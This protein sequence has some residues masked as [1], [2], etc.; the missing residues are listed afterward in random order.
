MDPY[1]RLVGKSPQR[2]RF[3]RLRLFPYVC[4]FWLAIWLAAAQPDRTYLHEIQKWRQDYEAN[5]K[6]DNGWLSLAGLFWLKDGE[7][8][9]G[10]GSANTIVLPAGSAPETAGTFIFHDGKTRLAPGRGGPL[11]LNGQPVR[12]ETV[13]KPDSSGNPDRI[14]LGRLSMIVIQRGAR[15]GIRLWD[16]GSPVRR[17]FR[18]THWFPVQESYRVTATFHSYPQPKMIP[19]LNILGDTAPNPS[20]GFATF[21]MGGKPCRLEA[22]L[23]DNQLFFMF[24]DTTGG[25]ETYP[26]GRFLYSG[27]P[28]NGKVVL[29]FNQAHNP[30]C[31]FT[32]YATCPLPPRQNKLP[33]AIEAGERNYEHAKN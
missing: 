21:E 20:P 14:N 30:P 10:S 24:K 6:Q 2:K 5:L 9:F 1:A 32:P 15:F 11:I 27:L 23:E 26:A 18:G 12:A 16:N 31:A 29:D 19:I 3:M 28:K 17:E 33:V 4:C 8:R 22:V 13:V 7:N 25:N